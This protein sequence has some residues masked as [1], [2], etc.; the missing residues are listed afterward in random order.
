VRAADVADV[1]DRR[2]AVLWRS[3]H[4]PA[5]HDEL[6]LALGVDGGG[7]DRCHLIG[8]DAGEGRPDA[9]RTKSHLGE[10]WEW[11]IQ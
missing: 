10:I 9:G 2:A 11:L 6:E 5:C 3:W 8:K 4:T 1:G 7:D